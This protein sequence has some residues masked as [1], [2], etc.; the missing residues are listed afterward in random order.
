M[1][2][3]GAIH[4]IDITVRD[5][6]GSTAFYDE[7]LPLIGFRR[8]VDFGRRDHRADVL[9]GTESLILPQRSGLG[10]VNIE[11]SWGAIVL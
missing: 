11:T 5:L 1:E 6:D 4:H 2:L 3:N 7:V 10:E 9:S 8:G